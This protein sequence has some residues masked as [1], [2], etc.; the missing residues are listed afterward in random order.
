MKFKTAV[1][2][3]GAFGRI[4]LDFDLIGSVVRA[5]NKSANP[6]PTL[7]DYHRLSGNK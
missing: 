1:L 3:A 5:Q 4:R 6:E 2:N 7:T